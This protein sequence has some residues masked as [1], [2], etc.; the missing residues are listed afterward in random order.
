MSD[1]IFEKVKPSDV[2]YLRRLQLKDLNGTVQDSIEEGIV[3][4][5]AD[6]VRI[7][8]G[9]EPI[10]YACIGTHENYKDII[11][12][13]FII[14]CYRCNAGTILN[15]LVSHYKCKEWYVNTHDFF[16][17]PVMFDLRLPYKIDAY[18]FKIDEAINVDYKFENSVTLNIT[19][20]DELNEVYA[21][22]MQDGFYS[23]GGIDSLIPRIAVKEMY[24]LRVC[25]KLA[26][27]GFIGVL[28]RTPEYADIAM[29]I[30]KN[31]RRKGY[32]VLLVKAL[33]ANCRLLGIKPTAVCDVNN[34]ASRATLQKAGFYL[35]GCILVSRFESDKPDFI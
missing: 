20:Q 5:K 28:A 7:L 15:Q 34:L 1:F 23:G 29:I 14:G 12:E 33:I 11:L 30:D 10:G 9:N 22:I 3:T 6:F 13:Y 16:A 21:L 4:Y 31:K 24:S 18:K 8:E 26:G 27:I 17:L 35:D 25:G 19:K 2:D 32:G